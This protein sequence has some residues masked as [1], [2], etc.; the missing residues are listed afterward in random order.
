MEELNV[1][2]W[3][4][5]AKSGNLDSFNMLVIRY[6]QLAY[7]TALRLTGTREMAEDATQEAFISAWKG[8]KS[9]RGDNFR[10][11]LLRIV[12]NASYDL[13]RSRRNKATISLDSIL[14]GGEEVGGAFNSPQNYAENMEISESLSKGLDSLPL[15]Q[16][17][18]IVLHDIQ[19]LS[20]EEIGKVMKCSTGT[21][22]SRISRGRMQ[23]RDF[24]TEEGTLSI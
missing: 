21:V 8:I 17:T 6:Q 18:A 7:N 1:A 14:L 11:W 16:R 9:I 3:L 2:Q 24:L 19:G 20:Y 5:D 22:K 12:V 13:L 15:E 4:K 23:L 10:P